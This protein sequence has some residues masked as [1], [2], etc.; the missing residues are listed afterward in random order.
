MLFLIF[1]IEK[2]IQNSV[3]FEFVYVK[4]CNLLKIRLVN[5]ASLGVKGNLIT[6]NFVSSN[7]HFGINNS[8]FSSL[9]LKKVSLTNLTG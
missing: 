1:T 4:V 7:N 2:G 3:T 6:N 9:N 5:F 8:S